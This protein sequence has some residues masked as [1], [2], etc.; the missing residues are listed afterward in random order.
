M[1]HGKNFIGFELS[2]KGDE[3][4][5]ANDPAQS[6]QVEG[7]FYSA[8][9]REVNHVLEKAS[10]AFVIYRNKSGKEKAEFLDKIADEILALGDILIQ[11]AMIETGL[12][13]GRITGERGRTIG[14]LRSFADL[15][16]EGSWVEASIDNADPDRSPIPK[17]DLRKMLVPIGPVVVFGASNFPLAYSTAGGDT[18]SALA[19]GNPVIVKGHNSHPGT[20]ELVANAIVDAAKKTDMPDGVFSHLN[21]IGFEVGKQLVSSSVVKAVGFTGSQK[22]G[23]ALYDL[24]GQ[25]EEPIPVFAEMGSV[26]PVIILPGAL[27]NV[28]VLAKQYAGS[29]TLGSGQ[30]CTNPGLMLGVESSKLDDFKND[31]SNQIASV[32]PSTMLNEGIFN[33]YEAKKL[34]TIEQVGVEVIS[35]SKE[36]PAKSSG[37]PLVASV[38]GTEFLANPKL[39]EEVFGPFS[40]LVECENANQL[41]QIASSLDGQLTITIMGSEEDLRDN[42]KV[43]DQ[44]TSKTGRIIFNGV[45]TGVEVCASMQHGGPYPATTDSRFTS[46][47]SGA[48]KRF[49]RPVSFQNWP[50][51]LL[52]EELQQGNPLNI[53]RLEDNNWQRQ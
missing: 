3:T 42:A 37:I 35:S 5:T 34:S 19:A 27:D 46:V 14:Q 39:H 23:K 53:W 33:N 21:D 1:I 11:R 44:L 48:I 28:E 17:P 12:P 29:I 16:R 38:G 51:N 9:P 22:G 30:F 6:T 25:R 20:S 47:G 49:V 4:F 52:P 26:N 43:I 31:L 36:S 18:A 50:D 41:E 10:A 45:P 32:V 40:L 15:L 13:E 8:T 7:E 24:A 2:S